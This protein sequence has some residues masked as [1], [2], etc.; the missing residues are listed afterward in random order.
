[1]KKM[2]ENRIRKAKIALESMF[3]ALENCPRW[4]RKIIKWF[5]PDIIGVVTALREYYWSD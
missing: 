3:Q 4:K 2:N 5:W 1:M